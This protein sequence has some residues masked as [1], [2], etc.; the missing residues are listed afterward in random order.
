MVLFIFNLLKD[1]DV[2]K[3]FEV[4]WKSSQKKNICT[5]FFPV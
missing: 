4:V 1:L 3:N 5:A 2:F